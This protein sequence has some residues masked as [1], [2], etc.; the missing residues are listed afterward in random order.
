MGHCNGVSNTT[1]GVGYI[2]VSPCDHEKIAECKHDVEYCE[3]CG[4]CWCK[5]CHKE[6]GNSLPKYIPYYPAYPNTQPWYPTYPEWT[7]TC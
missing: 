7:I 1:S 5:K 6:W 2:S 3:G 4:K